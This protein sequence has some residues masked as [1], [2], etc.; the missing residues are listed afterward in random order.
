MFK[1]LKQ[2]LDQQL[3]NTTEKSSPDDHTIKLTAATLMFEVVKSDQHIDKT[4]LQHMSQLLEEH[5]AL[6]PQEVESLMLLAQDQ[7]EQAISLQGFT[8]HICDHWDNPQRC[9]LIEALWV[10]AFADGKIDAHE[11]HVIRFFF[12]GNLTLLNR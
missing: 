6:V 4:E 1:S 3:I 5:F 8:R 7:S 12:N 9:K 2:F 10:I 11:R